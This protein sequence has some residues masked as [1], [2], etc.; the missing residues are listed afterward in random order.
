IDGEVAV[1]ESQNK[2]DSEFMISNYV[3]AYQVNLKAAEG[4]ANVIKAWIGHPGKEATE[5]KVMQKPEAAGD[6]GDDGGSVDYE[7]TEEDFKDL[8]LAGRKWS[9]KLHSVSGEGW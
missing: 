9:G 2:I 3:L 5:I 1:I 7:M 4:E 8:E 6:E